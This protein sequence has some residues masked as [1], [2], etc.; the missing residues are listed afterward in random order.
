MERKGLSREEKGGPNIHDNGLGKRK[1]EIYS[2]CNPYRAKQSR[3]KQQDRVK[4]GSSFI[5]LSIHS[6]IRSLLHQT[7]IEL[8]IV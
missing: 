1:Y 7:L 4:Y 5:H 8:C 3:V 2:V 6:F